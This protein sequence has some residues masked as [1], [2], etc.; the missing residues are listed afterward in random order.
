MIGASNALLPDYIQ[1]NE[2]CEGFSNFVVYVWNGIF[3]LVD[4]YLVGS[5]LISWFT[6]HDIF[7]LDSKLLILSI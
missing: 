1:L 5:D 4:H 7:K 3:T 2:I 6:L